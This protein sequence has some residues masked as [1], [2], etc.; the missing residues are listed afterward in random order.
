MKYDLNDKPGIVPMLLYGLQW[1]AVSIPSVIIMGTV[2][3]AIH[4]TSFT[5]QV[6]FMQKLFGLM[7][8]TT[9]VQILWGHRLPLVIGP[10]SVLLIGI[11]SS[12]S[13][14]IPAIYT[15]IIIGGLILSIVAYSGLLRRIQPVFT[16]RVVTVILMLI[17]ITLSPVILNLIVSGTEHASFNFIYALALV[18]IL[19]F[20]NKKLN[21]IWKSTTIIWGMLFGS[22]IYFFIYGF[23]ELQQF[24]TSKKLSFILP[25]FELNMGTLL[26]FLFCFVALIVNELGSIEGLGQMIKAD[27]IV[28]RTKR[29]VGILGLSNIFS[30]AM[31]I[32][33]P[34][35]FSLS[36][37][38]IS[39][40]KCASRYTLI[41]AGI[42]LVFCAFFPSMIGLL[43]NIPGVVMGCIMLYLMASQLSS[44]LN[45]VMKENAI[46]NFN[47]GI[48]V[49]LSLMIALLVSFVPKEVFSGIPAILHPILSNGFVMGVISVLI[50]EHLVFKEKKSDNA[51]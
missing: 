6:F 4:S 35:D 40:T 51:L 31:G 1:W 3:A 11:V 17:A 45:M 7:G 34:V 41:P 44:G 36:A 27:N 9:I 19:V 50:L 25:S 46:S 29:G 30:G 28:N 8:V 2:V 14:G 26:S 10:A 12:A 5:E 47:H 23:P 48:I 21:G 37:G 13:V 43:I 33:G 42:G 24:D 18:F 32:I 15:S 16:P 49:G 22:I 39:S 38:I 20:V